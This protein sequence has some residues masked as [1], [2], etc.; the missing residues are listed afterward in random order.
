MKKRTR[1][2]VLILA[3]LVGCSGKKDK[4]Q[5]LEP[6]PEPVAAT[7]VEPSPAA[8]ASQSPLPSLPELA[9]EAD[10]KRAEKIALGHALFFDKRLSGANDRSCYSCHQ[11]EDGNGG[12]DPVAIGSGDKP[13]TRHAPVIWNT[14]YWRNAFYWDGRAKTLEDNVKGAWG[15]GNMGGAPAGAKPE[16]IVAA[17]DKRA[18]GLVAIAGYKKLF[19]AAFPGTPIKAEQVDRAIAEY[20]R[21]LVCKDTAYDKYAAGDKTALTD[22]QQKGLDL[23]AG[24]A[25][26]VT[27]HAPPFFSTA[28]GMDGGVYFNIGIG[29]EGV[30]EDKVDVGR[31]KVTNVATD[32]AAFKPPS[33]RNI[34]KSAPYF[35]NGSV[36]K[37]DDA[38]KLMSSGGITNKNK[39]PLL[40]DT[41]L[42]DAERADLVAFL[43]ALDCPGKLDEPK[44]P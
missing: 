31:M 14:G 2:L 13:L 20:M 3:A 42:T 44:L 5:K 26:C 19:D 39:T 34:S 29:T 33:L 41:K 35:H 12:H 15:A 22:Q 16:E 9:L 24:K 23:F 17:L 11:N 6:Q 1:S 36:A 40:E 4:E 37:L 28:M 8:R 32:W 30:A 7:P 18:A 43:G 21:T 27:C 25:K 38:V 10:P